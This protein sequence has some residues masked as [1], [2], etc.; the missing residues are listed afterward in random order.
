QRPEARPVVD[1][2]FA[3]ADI[4]LVAFKSDDLARYGID[5]DHARTVNPRLIHLTHSALGPE[6]PDAHHGGYDVLV[7]GR[8]GLGWVMNRSGRTAP[9][10]TRPAINDF[11]TGFVSAFAVLAALRHRDQTGEGQRVDTSL[12]GTAMSLATPIVAQF[13]GDDE[14]LDELDEDLVALRAAGVSFDEQRTHYEAR[15][16]AAEGV[17][18]L[19]FRHYQTADGIISVAALSPGLFQKFH[20]ITGLGPPEVRDVN[21]PGFQQLV[22]DAEALFA[23]RPSAEWLE[24]LG[25]GGYPCGPYN[26]PHE[27]IHDPQ[28]VANDFVVELEHPT[29][30]PYTTTGM[31]VRF[32]KAP[33]KIPG[34]SPRFGQHTTDVLVDIGLDPA[35]VSTLIDE[36]TVIDGSMDGNP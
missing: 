4:A 23:S 32:E 1:A 25:A 34:P 10:P 36:G 20:Q 27:A 19:Y 12:L 33:A 24:K 13:P 15:V 29:F 28:V 11:S 7:Q 26:L 16:E 22:K 5:W 3:W 14:A 6:G 35:I 31:P 17:F 18:Q 8:S 21:D 2:L 9:R 30:G